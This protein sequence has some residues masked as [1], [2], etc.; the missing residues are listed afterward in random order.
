M[1]P[2]FP[3][4]RHSRAG[5]VRRGGFGFLPLAAALLTGCQ[6][7]A[8]QA[9]PPATPVAARTGSVRQDADAREGKWHSVIVK[10]PSTLPKM[11]TWKK[12]NPIWWFQNADD[13]VPPDWYRPDNRCRKT[14]WRFRNPLHNFTF[15]VIGVADKEFVRSGRY[16]R[17][18][19]N[20]NGGWNVAIS[21]RKLVLL[22][23]V[24]YKGGWFEFHLGWR[25]RGNFGGKIN[26]GM[27]D[28]RKAWLNEPIQ[29]TASPAIPPDG[30]GP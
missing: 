18:V 9:V 29:R 13:P 28:E 30:T 8:H 17:R 26:V 2:V 3:I 27:S 20:P 10:P 16:P 5:L 22:P 6:T 4:T 11:S 1:S 12:L 15:Y 21:R 19:A 24:S 14:L 23:Y 7:T 25:N